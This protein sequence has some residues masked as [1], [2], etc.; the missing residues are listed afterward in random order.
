MTSRLAVPVR[1]NTAP[2]Q[3]GLVIPYITIRHRDGRAHF[4]TNDPRRHHQ[5]LLQARC[6][7]CGQPLADRRDRQPMASLAEHTFVLLVRPSDLLRGYSSEPGLHAECAAYAERAC[8]ML[9]GSRT[10]YRRALDLE[11]DRCAD[12]ACE[13]R[14]WANAADIQARAG[15]RASAFYRIRSPLHAY[16]LHQETP[17]RARGVRVDPRS[18]T[19]ARLVT[20]G[21][22]D[23]LETARIL[24]LGLPWQQPSC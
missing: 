17:G 19:T 12:P 24:L 11:S 16:Q 21:N 6:S 23:E 9:N 18:A 4:S 2:T 10:H 14:G 15:A 20:P 1:L 7:V 8:P 5:C 3:G 22:P 13:C